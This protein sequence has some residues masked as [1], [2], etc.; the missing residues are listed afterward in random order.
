[1]PPS[2]RRSLLHAALALGAAFA[3]PLRAAPC[4]QPQD[5]LAAADAMA[6]PVH[7]A[8]C[9]RLIQ[10]PPIFTWPLQDGASAYTV[11]LVHPDGHEERRETAHNWLAWSA[12]LAV[13]EYRW[14]VSVAGASV[15]ESLPRRFTID[16][17]AV[18]FVVPDPRQ[19]VR[20]ARATA[21]P[22]SWGAEAKAIRSALRRERRAGVAELR[23]RVDGH[24]GNDLQAEPKSGSIES[25][26][27]DAVNEQKR[28]L[29]AA[30]AWLATGDGRYREEAVRRLLALARWDTGGLLSHAAND[31]A[32]RTV[33]WTLAL[34][35]DWLADTLDDAQRATLRAAI[36]A[37]TQP[38]FEEVVQRIPR[39][40]YE[41]HP[42]VSLSVTAAIG[43]LMA[44]EIP[45]ADRW[46]A[47]TLVLA[48]AW[49]P[50]WGGDDGGYGNGTAQMLWDDASDLVPWYV[51]E[52][53]AGADFAK[54]AWSRGH[55]R[56]MA[57]F[58]PPGSPG[59][60]FGDGAEMPLL[61]PRARVAKAFAAFAPSALGRWHA[62]ALA[63]E[64]AARL[65]LLMA[66]P[67]EA[68]PA[69]LP[70][71]TP[72]AAF[73][74]S[75]GWVAMHSDLADP[76]RTSV[77]FKASGFGSHNHSHADQLAFV[78]D[79]AEQRLA[80]ASGYYDGYGTAHW[81]D[82]YKQTRA[83][84]AIT[85]D[86]GHGQG[87]NERRFGGAVT[88]FETRGGYDYA[89]GHAEAAYDGALT[90][91]QRSV[92]YLRPGVVL[93]YD[94]LASELPRRWEW[95]LHALHRMTERGERVAIAA[96]AAK[97]CV[98]MLA[99]PA[100]DFRQTDAFIAAP[101]GRDHPKQWHGVFAAK[102]PSTNAEFVALMRVGSDCRGQDVGASAWR[103]ANGRWSV[104]VDGHTVSLNGDDVAVR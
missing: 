14:R 26:Y 89:V 37:R 12:P 98:D 95:N 56:F 35:Y 43:A 66:P 39:N 86:G 49:S 53:A 33:D 1:M 22:R 45:E 103:E 42:S 5:F 94:R 79:A 48:A 17:H 38:M 87:E 52:R 51:L 88:R 19:A 46:L 81:K 41:S 23:A 99:A 101:N 71:G 20:R 36:R 40:P 74:P 31:Q 80:I 65:E 18:P 6:A 32:S 85:F 10:T 55:G 27:E 9:S 3:L 104:R 13:G 84:N 47:D 63:G 11:R 69:P 16:E 28:T 7:P 60:L 57:Y 61:E 97:L 93:V 29:D 82:W 96:G 50:P 24:L 92:V 54:R 64:D 4:T 8:A 91:A 62:A 30:F 76:K 58:L 90:T 77:Y 44:G 21:R 25:N 102:L 73:F 100:F 34:G 70:R 68:R 15:R 67:H 78:V 59:G 2:A 72:N 75:V 83:A